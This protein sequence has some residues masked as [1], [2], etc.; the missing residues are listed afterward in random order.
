ME[1]VGESPPPAA[2]VLKCAAEEFA[3][4][5]QQFAA[6][7]RKLRLSHCQ[8]EGAVKYKRHAAKGGAEDRAHAVSVDR[9]R[10]IPHV[11]GNSD[12][13]NGGF[14]WVYGRCRERQYWCVSGVV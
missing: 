10:H 7:R 14:I 13:A 12:V 1:A 5:E 3:A 6:C 2:D 8:A 11:G 4:A 9:K